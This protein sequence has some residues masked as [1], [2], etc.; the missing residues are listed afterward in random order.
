MRRKRASGLLRVKYCDLDTPEERQVLVEW[1]NKGIKGIK[2]DFFDSE[3]PDTLAGFKAIYEMAADNHLIVNC[4][5]ASKPT[6]E[7]H[8]YPNVLNREAVNGEEYGG[9]WV[10]Q[11]VILGLYPKL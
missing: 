8:T 9:F 4:H 7:R 10:N 2:A 1:A 5:G 6:G 3:D 11:A